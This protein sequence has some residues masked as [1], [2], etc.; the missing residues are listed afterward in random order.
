MANKTRTILVL[1]L[2]Q[3]FA[4]Q[5]SAQIT[6]AGSSVYNFLNL[7]VSSRL[8]ALGGENVTI[9]DGELSSAMLNPALLGDMTHQILSLNYSYYLPGI[10]GGTAIYGHSFGRAGFEKNPDTDDKPNCF[11]AG[12]Q[13]LD[14]GKFKYADIHGNLQGNTFTA[15]DI[16]IDLMYAR[17]LGSMFTVGVALKP[18]MSFY[19]SY[20]AFALAADVGGH[21]QT[22]DSALHVGLALRNVG[23][24][25]KG[26]YTLEGGQQREQLPLNLEVGISYRVK[27]A[28]LRFSMTIHNMQRWNL[29][30]EVT[31]APQ[32]EQTDVKW[33]DMMFRHT[34]FALDIIPKSERFYL[35]LSYNHRHR[36]EM[37]LKDQ[38]SFAGFAVGAGVRIKMLRFGFA[39]SQYT[40]SNLTYQASLSFDINSMLK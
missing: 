27:H 34:V 31:N 24:Q 6:G 20:S 38:R 4:A 13:Y 11:A 3:V 23:W 15:K 9:R 2:L 37:Q 14:Y 8:A 22:K 25:L 18:V 40:K 35:T 7:P 28:P 30:Y 36:A 26:F 17:Q 21:F 19:E 10:M 12:I 1:V 29:N 33:Y 5:A 32:D 39:L 16:Q